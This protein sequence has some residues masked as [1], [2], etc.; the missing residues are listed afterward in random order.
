M[1]Q[2]IYTVPIESV[3]IG[4]AVQDIFSLLCGASN[5]IEIHHI[6]LDANVSAESAVRLRL[7]RGTALTQGS[8][9]SVVT[10]PPCDA[11][12]PALAGVTAHI[13]DTTQATGTFTT[14]A[15]FYWDVALP[16]DDLPAPEDRF[17]CTVSQGLFLDLPGTITATTVSGFLKFRLLP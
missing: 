12:D 6:H 11:T 2:K 17:T 10:P 15:G 13:N 5:G 9:G 14:L 3:G 4:T 1:G 8:G 16:F 7:K